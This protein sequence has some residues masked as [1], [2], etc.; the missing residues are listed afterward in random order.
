MRQRW[1]VVAR[2]P[3]PSEVTNACIGAGVAAP[4]DTTVFAVAARAVRMLVRILVGTEHAA[5]HVD[6]LRTGLSTSRYESTSAVNL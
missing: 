2:V 4:L 5:G 1:P 3:E 6:A